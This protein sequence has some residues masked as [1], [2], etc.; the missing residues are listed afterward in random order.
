M[1]KTVKILIIVCII[2]VAGLGLTVGMLMEKNS[3]MA[4]AQSNVVEN[5]SVQNMSSVN[6][7]SEANAH[8][9]NKNSSVISTKDAKSRMQLLVNS[10]NGEGCSVAYPKLNGQK[11]I[12]HAAIYGME[13]NY[14]GDIYINSKTGK[15]VKL[16]W[17]HD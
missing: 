3:G 2:L 11:T 1:D 9:A 8:I 4:T 16:Y 15:L 13:G 5:Q 10:N 14:I 12:Y 17:L 7:N 6:N